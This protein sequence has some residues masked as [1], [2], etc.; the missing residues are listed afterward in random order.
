M[1]KIILLIILCN[2]FFSV[3]QGWTFKSGV[4]DFDGK[5]KTASIRG[6]ATNYPYN[7]PLLVINYFDKDDS[8]N[9]YITN[10]GYFSDSSDVSVL[11]VFNNEKD[12]IYES[13]GLSLSPDGKNI[14]MNKFLNPETGKF[15]SIYEFI[16]KLKK[17]SS[18]S[19]RVISKFDKNDIKFSLKGSTKAISYVISD[20][21]INSQI[22]KIKLD[23]LIAQEKLKRRELIQQEKLKK[24]DSLKK[25]QKEIKKY[26]RKISDIP[27]LTLKTI[28]RD[29]MVG[30][31]IKFLVKKDN[32]IYWGFGR[33]KDES[34][35]SSLEYHEFK[36]RIAKIIDFEKNEQSIAKTYYTYTL[37]LE[38]NKEIV[39]MTVDDSETFTHGVGFISLLEKA[40]KRYLGKTFYSSYPKLYDFENLQ[41]C[42]I[43]KITF[44]EDDV[45]YA[46]LYGAFNVYFETKGYFEDNFKDHKEK[47]EL[48]LI[49]I[50][51]TNTYA[52]VEGYKYKIH[53]KNVFENTFYS[54]EEFTEPIVE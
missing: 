10:T 37:Q 34:A 21:I 53:K 5:Y 41:D 9:F 47:G 49:N 16:E 1:K 45:E 28:N 11:C 42:K 22:N 19:T 54:P 14:F 6:S 12:V 27:N 8:L 30:E 36:G 38:D 18:V 40:R 44:A 25:V 31:K 23:E 20:E 48:K 3:A 17:A 26:L 52:P 29:N 4:N 39:F 24:R 15:L 7:K 51:F 13:L 50:Q 46:Q 43:T 32:K 35:N 33:T 2:S